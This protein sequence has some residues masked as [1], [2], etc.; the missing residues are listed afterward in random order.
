V[1][2][3]DAEAHSVLG[4]YD[5]A[6]RLFHALLEDSSVQTSELQYLSTQELMITCLIG[7][8]RFAE[9]RAMGLSIIARYEELK[10]FRSAA[11]VA[12]ML[13]EC[14]LFDGELL[15]AAAHIE[16][17]RIYSESISDPLLSSRVHI[18]QAHLHVQHTNHE[19][20]YVHARQAAAQ[21][22][23]S[24][25]VLYVQALLLM[26]RA[27]QASDPPQALS[28]S[29]EVRGLTRRYFLPGL[30]MRV[31]ILAGELHSQAGRWR[32]ARRHYQ[33]AFR[34]FEHIQRHMPITLQKRFTE[35][36]SQAFHGLMRAAMSLACHDLAFTCLERRNA[37]TLIN[38]LSHAKPQF[39]ADP[40]GADAYE[41]RWHEFNE[42]R[43]TY[44]YLFTQQQSLIQTSGDEF[45]R[46]AVQI[47]QSSQQIERLSEQI[48]LSHLYSEDQQPAQPSVQAIQQ[49]LADDTVAVAYYCAGSQWF[50]LVASNSAVTTVALPPAHHEQRLEQLIHHMRNAIEH[51][52]FLPLATHAAALPR[53]QSHLQALY[54]MLIAPLPGIAAYKKLLIMPYGCLHGLPFNLLFNQGRYLIQTHEIS[55]LPTLSLLLRPPLAAT[56][57][58]ARILACD[59]AKTLAGPLAGRLA[60]AQAVGRI[61]GSQPY[62]NAAARRDL[63]EQPPTT[64]LH[65]AAHGKFM[66]T[67]MKAPDLSFI[68]LGDGMVSI[69]ETL[70]YDMRYELVTLSACETALASV[71]A[72]NDITSL[73]HRFLYAG[74]D[75]LICSLWPVADEIWTPLWMQRCYA[76]L[77]EGASKSEAVCRAQR[78]I[79]AEHPGLHPALWGAFQLIGDPRPFRIFR[80]QGA[81][82]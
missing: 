63:L 10:R 58:Q 22:Q 25:H 41:R 45:E 1:L 59:A 57:L 75:A 44:Y 23:A 43:H 60:E 7:L 28:L 74:A 15:H 49:L 56:A 51:T 81:L 65:L 4:K 71:Q 32:Q 76:A 61:T 40:Q 12:L 77:W 21:I 47:R 79:L 11:D 67:V 54:A 26:A 78:E 62:F 5:S 38:H 2:R 70:Q 35:D 13:A 80:E 6:L 64:V 72:D 73:A 9:A 46:I 3:N 37:Q 14:D 31:H 36:G 16:K 27:L 53:T 30:R 24:N 34:Q 50:A 17:A 52:R 29:Q 48:F 33:V 82:L 39:G 68:E 55:L 20:A 8:E 69:Y 19:L 18:V 42:L 66:G